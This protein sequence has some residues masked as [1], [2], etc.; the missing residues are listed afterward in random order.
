MFVV[1]GRFVGIYCDQSKSN[2][3]FVRWKEYWFRMS[4]L[5][6]LSNA[7]NAKKLK[8]LFPEFTIV[9]IDDYDLYFGPLSSF[10]ER[11][12]YLAETF[13]NDRALWKEWKW[14]SD[15][16]NAFEKKIRSKKTESV[17][18]WYDEFTND[19]IFLRMVCWFLRD[20]EGSV[21][22]VNVKNW[23][24][25]EDSNRTK[26]LTEYKGRDLD[27]QERS[28]YSDEYVGIRDR[29]EMLREFKEGKIVFLS[30]DHYD[31]DILL[32]I[33]KEWQTALRVVGTCLIRQ[34][35]RGGKDL[36]DSFFLWR[37]RNL[38]RSGSVEAEGDLNDWRQFR[39]R[40]PEERSIVSA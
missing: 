22:V 23:Y 15:A 34:I 36:T 5:H 39:I 14:I 38:I 6:I 17:I 9:S 35:D 24:D 8:D 4:T 1:Y 30:V 18:V 3:P 26:I 2:L 13:S 40:L 16:I 27:F 31:S 32:S 11:L 10:P 20:Y 28:R 7:Y 33:T 19:Q 12:F 25:W 37:I 29:K 21:K